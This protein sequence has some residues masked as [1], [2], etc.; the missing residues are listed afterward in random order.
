[1]MN[2]PV[3]T[4]IFHFSFFYRK[5]HLKKMVCHVTAE[6]LSADSWAWRKYGQ[7]PIKGSPYPR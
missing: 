4:S 6:N 2:P 7:K 3:L 5:N 1:M